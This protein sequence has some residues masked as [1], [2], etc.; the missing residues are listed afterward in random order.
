M[1]RARGIG[2][3]HKNHEKYD[4]K[5]KAKFVPMREAETKAMMNR[6]AQKYPK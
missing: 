4:R 5:N 3:Q 6:E 1:E 2:A